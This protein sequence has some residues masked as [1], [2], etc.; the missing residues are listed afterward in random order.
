M[1]AD[2]NENDGPDDASASADG[3]GRGRGRHVPE[4]GLAAG[5]AAAGLASAGD[6]LPPR[7][8]PQILPAFR[9]DPLRRLSA[10]GSV[11][12][13]AVSSLFPIAKIVLG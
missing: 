12:H 5:V 3:A 1:F 4:R 7:P 6:H 11:P 8:P 13:A 2:E 9:I 10:P